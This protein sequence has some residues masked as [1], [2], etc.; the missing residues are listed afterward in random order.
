MLAAKF[1]IALPSDLQWGPA[2]CKGV[3]VLEGKDLKL[4]VDVSVPTDRQ[5]SATRL[6]LIVYS[7]RTKCISILEVVCAW[8]PL[9]IV[10]EKQKRAKYQ[11]CA[12]ILQR[13]T[14]DR[15]CR[16]TPWWWETWRRWLASGM[17]FGRPI[18]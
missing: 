11:E 13:N 9:V 8:E 17:N 2:G 14:G 6:D 1:D 16:Y 15:R 5:L 10:R 4:V 18:S 7:W 3:G 12:R